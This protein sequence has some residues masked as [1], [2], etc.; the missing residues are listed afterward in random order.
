MD[1]DGDPLTVTEVSQPSNGSAKLN[2]DNTILYAPA[3]DFYGNDSFTYIISDGNGGT[4]VAS[5]AIT[6]NPV[7]DP[8][9]ADAGPDQTLTL[10]AGQTSM[11]VTLDGTGSYDKDSAIASYNW[12]GAPDPADVPQPT[13][14]L[15]AGKY[16]FTLV[17]SD[18]E[19]AGSQPSSVVIVI[20]SPQIPPEITS[21]P[22]INGAV[23]KPYIY[24]VEAYD[25][26]GDTL[27]YS[28]VTA[29][30][31]MVI[32][33]VTGLIQWTPT[34][35][36]VGSHAVT[37]RVTDSGGLYASQNF[38]VTVAN[39]NN[40]PIITSSPVTSVVAGQLYT[41]DVEATDPDTGDVLTFSLDVSP[42]GMTIDPS[43]G[44]IN[45]T[46]IATDEG[47]HTVEVKVSDG[48]GGEALD[49][50][51]ISVE[52]WDLKI[53][54]VQGGCLRYDGQALTV[55]GS[56]SANIINTGHFDIDDPIDVVFFEDTNYDGAFS[57]DE[58]NVLGQT[59]VPGPLL[60]GES[61]IVWADIAGSVRFN[62]NIIWAITDSANIVA[63][64][65]EI[66]NLAQTGEGCRYF[67]GT[68]DPVLEWSKQT[69]SV[70][71]EANIVL[72]TPVVADLNND[73]VS[74]IIF[75]TLNVEGGI[76]TFA[77]RAISGDGGEE[78][79]SVTD[80]NLVLSHD[81]G[82]AVG[83]ID[84]DGFP[85]IIAV[86]GYAP[87]P[88]TVLTAFEHDGSFKWKS[89]GKLVL[90]DE[91][92][93]DGGAPSIA[94]LDHDGIPEIIF[95]AKVFNADGTLRWSGHDAGGIG[96]GG[97]SFGPLSIVA[98]LDLDGNP[99]VV[100]G[101][102]AYHAD[103]TLY[104]NASIPD[105]YP[106]VGNFDSDPFPEIVVVASPNVY[107]LEHTG[108][109]KW[110]P[111]LIAGVTTVSSA[112]AGGP[113]VVADL[114]GDTWP[115]IGV[116]GASKYTVFESDGSIKWTADTNDRGSGE[117]GASV[118]DLDSDGAIE[119][120]YGDQTTLWIFR[121]ADG[122]VLF[123][124][125]KS[126]DTVVEYP[127]V[128]DIDG[129]GEAEIIAPAG[130]YYYGPETGIF[131]FGSESGN[132]TETRGVWNQHTYHITNVT[133]TSGIP[134]F[135]ENSW[136]RECLYR[137]NISNI[138]EAD[139]SPA[140]NL[141]VSYH[142]KV[143][144]SSETTYTVRIG[145]GGAKSA[146]AGISVELFDGD[147]HGNVVNIGGSTTSNVLAP[148]QFEDVSIVFPLSAFPDEPSAKMR[149]VWV[150]ADQILNESNEI[151]N[152]YQ[153]E[154]N[155][156]PIINSSPVITSIPNT[157]GTA[158]ALYEYDVDATDLD[159]DE[160][161]YSLTTAPAGMTINTS[162]GLIEWTPTNEQVGDN[163]VTV[164]VEDPNGLFDSQD[165]TVI[166]ANVDYPPEIISQPVTSATE[167]QL[168]TYDVEATDP[169]G[170]TLTY[171]LT[172]A[173]A[174]MTID[175]ATGLIQWT[176]SGDQ[177]GDHEVTIRVED[178]SS[179]S[180]SQS[181]QVNV[182]N[183]SHVNNP[184]VISSTPVLNA[185]AGQLYTYDVEADDP[186][187]GD[188]LTY[189]L[190]IA[191]VGMTIDSTTGLIQW[192]PEI[193]QVGEN[194]VTVRVTDTA[195]LYDTQEFTINVVAICDISIISTP[196]TVVYAPIDITLE[197]DTYP[198]AQGW[199]YVPIKER[200]TQLWSLID[201]TLIMDNMGLGQ[202]VNG[203][204]YILSKVINPNVPF[205]MSMR[206][207]STE[208]E[209]DIYPCFGSWAHPGKYGT[210]ST[211][212]YGLWIGPEGVWFQG[213][214][215]TTFPLISFD[216]ME[217]HDY[218]M[219]A[220]PG[221]D[222]DIYVDD[223]Y[224]GTTQAVY[225]G[226]TYFQVAFG[227]QSGSSN[228]MAEMRA[229]SFKQ[230][231]ETYIYDVEAIGSGSDSFKYT[232]TAAP[233][234][235]TI[236]ESTGLIVWKPAAD[237]VGIHEVTVEVTNNSGCLATQ[238]FTVEFREFNHAPEIISEPA[239]GG[240]EGQP[241][242]YDVNASDPDG[243]IVAYSLTAAPDG[244]TI[245]RTSGLIQWTQSCVGGC[246]H[247]IEVRAGDG[248]GRWTKQNFTIT[249]VNTPDAPII[250]STPVSSGVEGELY[251]YDVEAT[252]PD[253]DTLTYSLFDTIAENQEGV[254]TV[255]PPPVGMAIDSETGLIQWIPTSG[256]VGDNIVSVKV[257]DP[258]GL[259]NTQ[260]F[261]I[262]V[263]S[264][265][266][267]A[268]YIRPAVTVSVTP[269]SVPV[270]GTV[271]ISVTASDNVG[272]VDTSLL[273]NGTPVSLD[274]SGNATYSSSVPGIFT[275]EGLA[276]DEA[277]NEG[278][279]TR[280]FRFFATGDGITP[281]VA[282]TSPA[283]F[284]K[285]SVP[286]DIVGTAFDET[287]LAR[288]FLEYSEKD[289]NEFTTLAS[290]DIPVTNGILGQLD[291]TKLVNGLYDIRLSA[292]DT[293]GNY[294]SVTRT[295]QIEGEMKVGNFTIG[296]R[297]LSIPVAGLPVSINRTYDS[298]V[299]SS[300]DF[301]V[302]WSLDVKTI[303]LEESEVP[304]EGWSIVC[305]T[306]LFGTCIEWTVAPSTQHSVVVSMEG[307]RQQEFTV[308][309]VTSYADQS[310]AQGYLAF[311]A[312]TGTFSK[313]AALDPV[314]YEF[315][316][317]GNLV[318][319]DLGLIDPNRYRLTTSEGNIYIIDQESGV[320]S[321]IDL[322]GNS[323][324]FGEDG[325]IHSAG[326][327]VTF[328]RDAEG[329][330]TQITDPM[331]NIITY[332]YDF[333]G[334]LVAVTDQEGNTTRFT[335]NA[336][337]DLLDIIDPRGLIPARNEYDNDG[338]LIATTDA[339]GNRV[340]FTHNIGTRQEVVTDR[341]GYITV[342]EY[343]DD[344]NVVSQT[345]SM[346]N[347]TSYT[348][349]DRGNKL[350][351]TDPLGNTS[352]YIY[353]ERDNMLS[354]TDAL[355]NITTHTYN[356]RNQVLTTTDPLGNKTENTY[357]A[358]GNL[359]TTTDALGNTTSNTY[360]AYGNLLTTTDCMGNV[361]SH[362]YDASGNLISL[363]DGL[364][365]KTTYTYDANGN[366]ISQ[367]T[368]RTNEDGVVVT[369][370]TTNVYDA[371]NRV[372]KTI[373]P[374][375]NETITEYNAMGQQSATRDKNGNWT[376]Y[377][378]D[379][380][381][382]LFRTTYPDGTTDTSAYDANGNR[383]SSTNRDGNT[384]HFVYDQVNRLIQ[385][386]FPDDTPG[387]LTDNP[388][389]QTQYDAAGRTIASID[390]RGNMTSFVYDA[391][392]RRTK[393]IDALGNQ[394]SFFYDAN[395]NQ[396]AM[397]DA[398]GNTTTFEYDAL[399]R[400][401]R[402]IFSDTT[403]TTT[404]Y[405]CLGRKISAT[406]QAGIT[407][408]FVYDAL[409]R[410]IT[411]IDALGGQ[412]SYGYDEAG[413]KISQTDANG[414]ITLWVYDN[415]GKQTKH[416][417]PLGMSETFTYD[418]N[419]NMMTKTDF[420]CDTT[421]FTYDSCC[422]RLLSKNYPDGSQVSFTY[423]AGGLR[424][425]VTD[426]RGTT[427]NIY[428][429]R[430]R[431]LQVTNPDGSSLIY[432]YDEAG[433][434]TSVAIPSGTTT[435][436]FDSMN[437]LSSV[438]DPNGGIT[439]YAYDPVGNRASVTY[440]NGTVAK[441]TYNTL[442][443]LTYL[444]NSR[445]DA[446]IISSYT[447]TLG[448][449]GNRIKVVEDNGRTVDYTYDNLYRLTGEMITDPVLGNQTISYTYDPVGNRLA[450]TDSDGTT[451]YSYDGNDRLL[452]EGSNTYTYDPNGNTLSKSDGIN[453]TTYA[454]D[455]ENRLTSS[456][457]PAST[458]NYGYDV[459][460][461]RSSST[462]DGVITEYLVDKNRNYAQV[463]EEQ[464]GSGGLI[465]SYVYGDDLISQE[466][467]GMASYYHY[468]GLGSTRVLTDDVELATDT[469]CYEAFGSLLDSTGSTKNN[470]RFTGE[471]Y[472]QNV[473]FYYLRARY[474]DHGVGRF[475]GMDTFPG[476]SSRSHT[477]NRYL[478]AGSNPINN[479]DPTGK[480]YISMQATILQKIILQSYGARTRNAYLWGKILLGSREPNPTRA[481]E[482]SFIV[483]GSL[484][485]SVLSPISVSLDALRVR[486]RRQDN[487]ERYADYFFVG[488]GI[489][490]GITLGNDD[491][492]PSGSASVPIIP[493][494]FNS[495]WT[496]DPRHVGDFKGG[497][498][499]WSGGMSEAGYGIG[500]TIL[501]FFSGSYET[502]TVNNCGDSSVASL[503][504]IGMS[505]TF[506]YWFTN[507]YNNYF[508]DLGI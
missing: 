259:S 241:Y 424:E 64:V 51:T 268:D 70:A 267:A 279:A 163:G 35:A 442:N 346:G 485:V 413:N 222:F 309:A 174:G 118:Y 388:R 412:T 67:A 376:T 401:I 407:T 481:F 323:I 116:A 396:A 252:D 471:Q 151:D 143:V 491:G 46:P 150:D 410:L 460:G 260:E 92:R 292:E 130:N 59:V 173:P 249:V 489:E 286:T 73:G 373:D 184:P 263:L 40:A 235:M 146:P 430:N 456:Q 262:N 304:G 88:D 54:D 22:V 500:C 443:R 383:I 496:P 81:T 374:N 25:A 320:E 360:D 472:D 394:T 41:Y 225:V 327:S 391:V 361:T 210:E 207:R 119:I 87:G 224:A 384:T 451:S 479:L 378:Y 250:I 387:D 221:G 187:T 80:P 138:P 333:Y 503:P 44:L 493:N 42:S 317:D 501:D 183:V 152:Y 147:P 283:D 368:S 226:Y 237:Q 200:E 161:T 242:V 196:K 171:S 202:T 366:Q 69:F 467:T 45:W 8:P 78:L 165:F 438:T 12:T 149:W 422:N 495:F 475:I 305:K 4:A 499:V 402:T 440:P 340:E 248:N 28:L 234:G 245:N 29:P 314:S 255:I 106:A 290:S 158:G 156:S 370:I 123:D 176:P 315:L 189:S 299:K 505:L 398:N 409:G 300:G 19:G 448:P 50:F 439:T 53:E 126:S 281:T 420:N 348:Y 432:T 33:P 415:L 137:G 227:D 182:A 484:S 355:G 124:F 429:A 463:L 490:E 216:P 466:R 450:K 322:N 127:I 352:T 502:A 131:V 9:V 329:R 228:G 97:T 91:Q 342:Y 332:Q 311:A 30:E 48:R 14:L 208:H 308:Q 115:E 367:T 52:L 288:Y 104:W 343:D 257:E 109:V 102:S 455:F 192:T 436:A 478:Y 403:L 392:G 145:N 76:A 98:D 341:L 128:A 13:V 230:P 21:D 289:K 506:G 179:L 363:T 233:D 469:Y 31:G 474:Y 359:L 454:Y 334:D 32:D 220:A 247:A 417:L 386:I 212:Q 84:A 287:Q 480:F 372:I 425:T 476:L 77:L 397:T 43:T 446:S 316:T 157:S 229:F 492:L 134:A 107:L 90:P 180:D 108:E 89:E 195:G 461:I 153:G 416:T 68:I 293:A 60:Q 434:R 306:S 441:Y 433:N 169:D 213:K 206:A 337:H 331:G 238:S 269:E 23:D 284:A 282:I 431:L 17:V 49:S 338:R 393:V 101:K 203:G 175:P 435:Y 110:G 223:I 276:Y 336:R 395:G 462:V 428:D 155:Q 325:I 218:R 168:Y 1:V 185:T 326:K 449:N 486:I 324:T 211:K 103:G 85:E 58:D 312:Q 139:S 328:S 258:G 508:N 330:I 364:G 164:K 236:D 96:R 3:P 63:E 310:L 321:I 507:S 15:T 83:D 193:N 497:G 354:Q 295:Y 477:L 181:F 231:A 112:Y 358:N 39:V 36:Q 307:I 215:V 141:T 365:N 356:N 16:I 240:V 122:A 71:A 125:P 105:G 504:S 498:T 380:M 277:G 411:V 487:H 483:S 7:N 24:D 405:D 167:G 494:S 261:T 468:D 135:E 406:D 159:G 253:G 34:N 191:P 482:L 170:D 266:Q 209:G 318:D 62:R 452:S 302:G 453:S 129:D 243:D 219:E 172:T 421:T 335:Y 375:G 55:V 444:E 389:T 285:I 65:D 278:S 186:D 246:E 199:N 188:L 275:A 313:L 280:E 254:E 6:V 244:M 133:D 61:A 470:Y 197:F 473:G 345:D 382:N 140:P 120:I 86:Y 232:L 369:M 57:A 72:M 272:V 488:L 350:T 148:G 251:E 190:D 111:V 214:W 204:E 294:A 162:S 271:V 390:E 265:A 178:T 464:D 379:A 94:D 11:E 353:D 20:E 399:N 205:T 371:L 132:W 144:T 351:E 423:T 37:V 459:D 18:V 27:T 408:S 426:A 154:I 427:S 56:I 217:F 75:N 419:G 194:L 5:V 100:A 404:G 114:D 298:R 458:L 291:P 301:G 82:L 256:Q 381:G 142:R 117:T 95:G 445:S 303:K 344:G 296:F 177:V 437:R 2:P 79:W 414:N 99:E 385:T 362:A 418:A 198:S 66:N 400:Q 273:V 26:N 465:V 339:N 349:D 319:Y 113:P 447:Y 38:T 347:T 121:G 377:E 264:K 201:G 297:D 47:N 160:L 274:A 457:T 136:Q 270:G 357:D 239:A 166:V 74:D 10:P 93:I